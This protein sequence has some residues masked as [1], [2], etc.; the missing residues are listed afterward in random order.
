M[1]N[2][3]IPRDRVHAWSEA[4]AEKPEAHGTALPR[5]LKEQKRLARWVGENA[6]SMHPATG[7]IANYMISVVARI[8]DLAGGKLKTATWDQIRA[9]EKRVMAEVGGLLPAD[10]GFS[11][12]ARGVSR[13]Q[14]HI[15]DEAL[16]ALFE[17]EVPE[18][19]EEPDRTEILKIYLLMWVA[20]E[21]LDANWTPPKGFAGEAEYTYVHIE[22][23]KPAKGDD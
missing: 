16:L 17:T 2:P 5:L 7:G 18:G 20:T 12:R 19:E 11:E 3:L 4:I 14:A 13:A 9:T 22:P 1:A 21:V 15:L 23:K 6:G 10:E 8:F